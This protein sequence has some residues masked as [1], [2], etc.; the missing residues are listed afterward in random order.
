MPGIVPGN[1]NPSAVAAQNAAAA[2][3]GTVGNAT[4][5]ASSTEGSASVTSDILNAALNATGLQGP[6]LV[7]EQIWAQLRDG[8]MWRSLGWL[9]LG[10]LL[11]FLGA[12]TWI[13]MQKNP[14]SM[15]R[16][17]VA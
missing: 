5:P 12:A 15:V 4:N 16:R 11:I 14:L 7:T 2:T 1:E 9:V 6:L 17:A 8:K 10:I 13:G 3:G